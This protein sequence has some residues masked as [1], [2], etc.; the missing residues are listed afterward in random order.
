M[1]LL[2]HID[3][4]IRV[5]YA[6]C[7]SS[8]Q[9]LT[10]LLFGRKPG[11]PRSPGTSGRCRSRAPMARFASPSTTETA[12]AAPFDY[13]AAP[14][15]PPP[16]TT[17]SLPR[18]EARGSIHST[19][20][21]PAGDATRKEGGEP[22]M[23]GLSSPPAPPGSGNSPVSTNGPDTNTDPRVTS[24]GTGPCMGPTYA[25]PPPPHSPFV[26]TVVVAST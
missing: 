22:N 23:G 12:T 8:V 10:G 24:I 4:P 15:V 18:R 14:D 16:L 9:I 1:G 25:G 3:P 7:P 17:S 2:T 11:W 26:S 20:E 21:P 13:Q 6:L 19:C 5:Q